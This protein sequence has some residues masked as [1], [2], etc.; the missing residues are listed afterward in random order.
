LPDRNSGVVR[1]SGGQLSLGGAG[2]MNPAA[3]LIR[4]ATGN[5]VTIRPGLAT[6]ASTID[7]IGGAFDNNNPALSNSGIINDWGVPRTSALTNINK[8][9]LVKAIWMCSAGRAV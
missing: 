3:G 6:N 9:P 5:T 7:L 4:A 1:G 8:V 2:N